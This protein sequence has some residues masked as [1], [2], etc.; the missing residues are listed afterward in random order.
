[1]SDHTADKDAVRIED[2]VERSSLGTPEA[3]ALRATVSDEHAARIVARARELERDFPHDEPVERPCGL[4]FCTHE[5]HTYI[6]EGE[7]FTCPLPPAVGRT[8]EDA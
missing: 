5:G 2:L 4:P 7:W 8:T 3:K 6:H 1:M